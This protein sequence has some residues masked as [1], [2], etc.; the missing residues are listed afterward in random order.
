MAKEGRVAD[1]GLGDDTLRSD[2]MRVAVLQQRQHRVAQQ[3][4]GS[5][6]TSVHALFAI[7][8]F[9]SHSRSYIADLG[10]KEQS[11]EFVFHAIARTVQRGRRSP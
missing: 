2:R 5:R 8:P 9:M 10:V 1:S 11:D 6:D 3:R 7:T 4:T